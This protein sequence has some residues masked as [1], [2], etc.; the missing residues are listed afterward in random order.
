[1]TRMFRRRALQIGQGA[2]YRAL[3]R[4]LV[5]PWGEVRRAEDVLL[6]RQVAVRLLPRAI[7]VDS[8]FAHVLRETLRR[9]VQDSRTRMWHTSLT[10]TRKRMGPSSSSSRRS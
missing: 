10:T 8:E 2:R 6:R 4:L 1:V 3:E 9:S 5:D 7:G